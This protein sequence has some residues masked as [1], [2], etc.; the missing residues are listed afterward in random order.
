MELKAPD[1]KV[2]FEYVTKKPENIGL[3]SP[4]AAYFH[5]V[6]TPSGET[7]TNVAPNDHPHHRGIFLA[8]WTRSFAPRS[9]FPRPRPAM[10]RGRSASRGAISGLGG[11]MLPVKEGSFKT[12]T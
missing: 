2:V 1:G 12:A 6:N 5:P 7:V 10:P 4:S 3:T 9:I 8:F 11:C